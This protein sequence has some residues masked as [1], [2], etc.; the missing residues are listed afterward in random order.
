MFTFCIGQDARAECLFYRGL[1]HAP[2]RASEAMRDFTLALELK[3][4][5]APAWLER[6]LLHHREHEPVKAQA[7]LKKALDRGANPAF[8]HYHLA[9]VHLDQG[10]QQAAQISLRE[11]LRSRPTFEEALRL[12]QKL[13]GEP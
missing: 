11:A 4:Q 7:D 1:A 5:M 13:H 9:L 8:I 6:G 2:Q 3:P 10:D 12:Q